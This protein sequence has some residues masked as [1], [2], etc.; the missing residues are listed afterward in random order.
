MVGNEKGPDIHHFQDGLYGSW[1]SPW[2]LVSEQFW[3]SDS[4]TTVI[5]LL[6]RNS[7]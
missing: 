1:T 6:P 7:R 5:A 4:M 3:E 2:T